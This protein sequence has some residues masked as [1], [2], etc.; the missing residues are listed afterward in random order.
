MSFV[1]YRFVLLGVLPFFLEGWTGQSSFAFAKV[2]KN[3]IC[4][5]SF[6][7]YK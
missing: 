1:F 4:A 2:T 5:K 7:G 6:H 3:L